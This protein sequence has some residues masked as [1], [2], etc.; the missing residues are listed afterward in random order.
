MPNTNTIEIEEFA[1]LCWLSPLGFCAYMLKGQISIQPISVTTKGPV[2]DRTEAITMSE[3][4]K[5]VLQTL[6]SDYS[7]DML[8]YTLKVLLKKIEVG[9]QA[10]TLVENVRKQPDKLFPLAQEYVDFAYQAHCSLEVS[11]K[12][13]LDSLRFLHSHAR[14]V[15]EAKWPSRSAFIREYGEHAKYETTAT[16]RAPSLS[17]MIEHLSDAQTM[18]EYYQEASNYIHQCKAQAEGVDEEMKIYERQSDEAFAILS[19]EAKTLLINY[20]THKGMED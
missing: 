18:A 19:D 15:S 3:I 10:L 11:G 1:A 9:Q 14:F 2:W 16:T 17:E 6:I 4:I 7:R 5:G 12:E 20:R 13:W 8:S